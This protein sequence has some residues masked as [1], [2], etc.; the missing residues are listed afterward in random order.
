MKA[1]IILPYSGQRI[2]NQEP[3]DAVG[4]IVQMAEDPDQSDRT[5]I[6]MRA[7][8]TKAEAL[9]DLQDAIEYVKK[10]LK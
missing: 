2:Y 6:V 3:I 1:H 10:D 5:I 7:G 8:I 4:A 9:V